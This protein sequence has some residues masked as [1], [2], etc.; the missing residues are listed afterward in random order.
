MT[1]KVLMYDPP[2]GWKY[3]FPKPLPR[4]ATIHYGG[5]DYGVSENFDI[6]EWILQEGYPQS[7]I[8]SCGDQ[9]YCKWWVENAE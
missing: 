8:D 3:G 6:I 9:F 7:E 4:W 5:D 2:S 1:N